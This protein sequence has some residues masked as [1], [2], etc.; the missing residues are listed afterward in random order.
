MAKK[1]LIIG[2]CGSGKTTLSKK[3]SLISNLPVIHLDK[4][5]WNPGWII[6]ETEK[7]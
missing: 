7:R 1:I 4:H 6:T 3:L 5:Y 2:N